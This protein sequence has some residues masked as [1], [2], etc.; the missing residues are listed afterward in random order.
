MRCTSLSLVEGVL[1]LCGHEEDLISDDRARC[2]VIPV[3][4]ILG[5]PVHN[6]SDT[7]R[8][9]QQLVFGSE[10]LLWLWYVMCVPY[11]NK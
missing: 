8:L 7:D 3:E 1:W 9:T 11:Q 4:N 2:A 10:H 6:Y 5:L